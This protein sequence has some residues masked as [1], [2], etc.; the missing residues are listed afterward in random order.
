MGR[1]CGFCAIET[2]WRS[3][4]TI[5]RKTPEQLE[6]VTKEAIKDGVNHMVITTGSPN[7]RG[8]GAEMIAETVQ[9]LKESFDLPIHVQLTPPRISQIEQ[10]FNAGADSIGL[11]VETF[12]KK[13]IKK[14][15]PGK[16]HIDFMEPLEFAVSLFGENQVSSFVLGGLGEDPGSMRAGFED[17]ISLGVIPYLVPFRPLH[18][19]KLEGS[20]PPEASYMRW[21]Y[22]ELAQIMKIY[23]IDLKK[24]L[25]G[26]VKCGACSA[27]D[28]ALKS[29][30]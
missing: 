27:I 17:L 26:C 15:C 11:H 12:D 22:I 19:S 7:P 16:S 20:S 5:L 21:L 18:G 6:E 30:G 24:N 25:A 13:V 4:S 10:I 29:S 23:G 8:H 1:G 2:S 28:V 14:V 3:G 9:H